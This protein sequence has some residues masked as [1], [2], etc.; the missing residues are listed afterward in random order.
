[1]ERGEIH[2]IEECKDC[3]RMLTAASGGCSLLPEFQFK[4]GPGVT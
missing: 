3:K 2:D 4:T 1:M